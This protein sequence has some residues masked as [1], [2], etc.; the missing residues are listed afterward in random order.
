[1]AVID[2]TPTDLHD[3]KALGEASNECNVTRIDGK[4][5]SGNVALIKSGEGEDKCDG[6]KGSIR[7][8]SIII[9]SGK[10]QAHV[11]AIVRATVVPP[12]DS[13]GTG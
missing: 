6:Q 4:H 9:T 2:C 5:T 8:S 7:T 10:I 1:V 11:L 12:R 3:G 13:V